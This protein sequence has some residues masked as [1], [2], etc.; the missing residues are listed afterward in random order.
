MLWG[1]RRNT[2]AYS[3][4]SCVALL[5]LRQE[6]RSGPVENLAVCAQHLCP[7]RSRYCYY[8]ASGP[9]H[10]SHCPHWAWAASP[11][12]L[13]Y[14]SSPPWLLLAFLPT[15]P[16]GGS[17]GN[18][19]APA[20]DVTA[21]RHNSPG[22]LCEHKRQEHFVLSLLTQCRFLV[23]FPYLR[24]ERTDSK[25]TAKSLICWEWMIWQV[26]MYTYTF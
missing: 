1:S 2:A 7:F 12:Q 24:L 17:S 14:C 5:L 8:C 20:W 10:S 18:T 15:V 21:W 19:C 11:S 9:S 22:L 3:H 16:C 23:C 26:L 4:A 6:L 13:G 25:S